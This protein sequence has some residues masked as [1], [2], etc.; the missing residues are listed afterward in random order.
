MRDLLSHRDESPELIASGAVIGVQ[1][2]LK[3]VSPP[4]VKRAQEIQQ[5]GGRHAK[6]IAK[7]GD[8][9]SMQA[10]MPDRCAVLISH[11]IANGFY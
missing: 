5:L 1:V 9:A 4:S 8:D 10:G 2:E 6:P 3:L 7:S 11:V